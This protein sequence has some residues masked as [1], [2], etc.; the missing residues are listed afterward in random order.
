MRFHKKLLIIPVIASMILTGC[1]GGGRIAKGGKA[2]APDFSTASG[3]ATKDLVVSVGSEDDE[4][5]LQTIAENFKKDN[6]D[7]PYTIKTVVISE[8]DVKNQILSDINSAPDVF[9]F[10]DDQLSALAASGIL[11][12]VTNGS[13]KSS[14]VEAAVKAASIG[15]KLYAYP[16]TA[17]NGYFMYYDKSFFS[18]SD[19]KSLDGMMKKAAAA[20]K[21]ITMDFSS[22]WYLYSFYGKTGLRL[23]LADDGLTNV[24]DWNSKKNDPTGLDVANAIYAVAQNKG[25]ESGGD[26][27]LTAGAKDGSVVAGVSGTWLSTDMAAVWGKNLG[28]T[29]LPTYTCNDRQ[30]QMASYAGYKMVGVNSYSSKKTWADKFAAYMTNNKSQTLRFEKRGQGPSNTM[31]ASSDEVKKSV[32]IQALLAQSENS[33]LQRLGQK[34]WDAS[35]AYGMSMVNGTKPT[36]KELDTLVKDITGSVTD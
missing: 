3:D 22:G 1:A 8:S 15:D 16:M 14:N 13:A 6:P 4:P 30:I 18:D 34:F 27:V 31:A 25:F 32:A 36:Q 7:F 29:K 9:T 21:K 17:D 2:A 33:S 12:E 35:S 19:L 26:D 20:G 11:T 23:G 10:A 28:A 5:V 24:C